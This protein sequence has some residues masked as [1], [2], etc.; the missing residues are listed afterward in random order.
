MI[1]VVPG[2]HRRATVLMLSAFL[3][4]SLIPTRAAPIVSATWD[5]SEGW[6][7]KTESGTFPGYGTLTQP[8]SVGG[9]PNVLRITRSSGGGVERDFV[10]TTTT[11]VGNWRNMG[12]TG[13]GVV[14]S[15]TFDFYAG[16]GGSV[17][18]PAGLRLYFKAD[19]GNVW[20]FTFDVTTIPSGWGS[21]GA[22]I[23]PYSP[24]APYSGWWWS[25]TGEISDWEYDFQNVTEVG[26]WLA[27]QPGYVN[28]IY[29]LD[30]FTLHDTPIP[31][32]EPRIGYLLATAFLSLGTA[33]CRDLRDIVARLTRLDRAT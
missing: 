22:N 18:Y 5:V 27:Y 11:L 30:N 8:G 16:A 29:A 9:N 3:G 12:G 7:N 26:I 31:I 19:S 25:T 23:N 24:Y 21:Y 1:S 17:D 6:T 4:L 15:I 32:P 13:D 20:Y 10:F 33:F 28:Q 2:T 14:R